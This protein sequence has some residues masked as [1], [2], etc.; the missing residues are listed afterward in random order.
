MKS[1]E[2]CS[3]S[4]FEIIV[5][6]AWHAD[7]LETTPACSYLFP[8]PSLCPYTFAG[9]LVSVNVLRL[10]SRLVVSD[11]LQPHGL[12]HANVLCPSLSPEVCSDSWAD[13]AI[14]P[15]HPLSPPFSS[16]SQSFP[17]SG[18]HPMSWLFIIGGQSI[19]V[20]ASASV[21]LMN[22]LSWFPLGLTGLISLLS[23][24]LSRVISSTNS[25]ASI[26]FFCDKEGS[27]GKL[28]FAW[29]RI[30]LAEPGWTPAKFKSIHVE[31]RSMLFSGGITGIQ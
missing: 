25:K 5:C 14:Q 26:L 13:D 27:A 28:Q 12:Q 8:I 4:V 15:S 21:L 24:E 19:G 16:C 10:F 1:Q 23:K 20:L 7:M 17:A 11:S 3:Q 2:G 6:V 30:N 9:N 18:S 31:S 22:F 29:T